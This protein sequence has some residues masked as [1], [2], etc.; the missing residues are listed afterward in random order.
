MLQRVVDSEDDA[1]LSRV[2]H[3]EEGFLA[4]VDVYTAAAADE[5]TAKIVAWQGK[6][7]QENGN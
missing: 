3:T 2:D 4:V 5:V 7:F 1:T 6:P